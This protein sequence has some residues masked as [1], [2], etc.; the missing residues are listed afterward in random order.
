M[1]EKE[2]LISKD[3]AWK[4][5]RLEL[6][7][8]YLEKYVNVGHYTFEP[9]VYYDFDVYVSAFHKAMN[10]QITYRYF[11]DWCVYTLNALGYLPNA[12]YRKKE[13]K[14]YQ[15][16]LDLLD[17]L[18]WV[19]ESDF[20]NALPEYFAELRYYDYA[21]R[22]AKDPSLPDFT[23]DGVY[24][25]L[26]EDYENTDGIGENVFVAFAVDPQNKRFEKRFVDGRDLK[27]DVNYIF[28][29]TE[30]AFNKIFEREYAKKGFVHDHGL[31]I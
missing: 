14:A 5:I 9:A 12:D 7:E 4:G 13:P 3:E 15:D 18:A 31:T 8:A 2:V 20:K 10:G 23:T 27:G 6:S 25:Y 1:K 24:R 28:I 26:Y 22:K 11:M 30:E 16:I 19:N 21:L 29:S 17:S